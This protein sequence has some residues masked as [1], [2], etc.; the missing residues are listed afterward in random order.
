MYIVRTLYCYSFYR[1]KGLSRTK[2]IETIDVDVD[3]IDIGEPLSD[4]QHSKTTPTSSP[5]H[6]SITNDSTV[7]TPPP[8]DSEATPTSNEGVIIDDRL[9][10]GPMGET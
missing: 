10:G 3:T 8:L 9:H 4:T 1:I 5:L 2:V 6:S 7:T